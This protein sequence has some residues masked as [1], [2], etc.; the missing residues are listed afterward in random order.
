MKI[1]YLII[2]LLLI[3]CGQ[4]SKEKKE[5]ETN[6]QDAVEAATDIPPK[7]NHVSSGTII[8]TA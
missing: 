6:M 8:E 3:S 4:G 7:E 5:P 1:Q 2:T